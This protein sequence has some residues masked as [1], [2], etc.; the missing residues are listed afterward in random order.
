MGD[1]RK[2]VVYKEGQPGK[3]IT[4]LSKNDLRHAASIVSMM[5]HSNT[6]KT[7]IKSHSVQKYEL[8]S[9]KHIENYCYDIVYDNVLGEE[10]FVNLPDKIVP[11]LDMNKNKDVVMFV[12]NKLFPV[13]EK[14]IPVNTLKSSK[15]VI[16]N[17][18]SVVSCQT[19]FNNFVVSVFNEGGKMYIELIPDP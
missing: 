17:M 15:D 1:F 11:I 10:K 12:G 18:T 8:D 13:A 4:E 7:L 3:Y 9:V 2:N 14:T 5:I 16:L 19:E 6:I